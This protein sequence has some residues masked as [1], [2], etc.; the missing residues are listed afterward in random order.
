MDVFSWAFSTALMQR[1][2]AWGSLQ[3]SQ[4]SSPGSA[5]QGPLRAAQGIS[6]YVQLHMT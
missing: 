4:V 3:K 6:M 5:P 2:T 1:F